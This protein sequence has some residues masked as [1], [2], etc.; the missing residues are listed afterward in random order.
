[1]HYVIIGNSAA[2]IGA[3]EAIRQVDPESPLTIISAEPEG[4]YSRAL[5]SYELAGWIPEGHLELRPPEFYREKNIET[6]LGRRVVKIDPQAKE[7]HLDDG[8][9][10][11][12]DKLLLATGGSPQKTGVKGEDKQGI[13]GFRTWGDLKAISEETKSVK[14]GVV[15]GGGCIGLQAACGLHHHGVKTTLAIA[16][17]HLLSQ[18]ADPECGDFFRELFEKNGIAVR[19]NAR[20]MEFKG[21][22]RVVSILFEDGSELPAQIV[23]VGKG[24]KPNTDLAEGTKIRADWG[25]ITDD[26]MR[27]DEADIFAA[28]DVA[29]TRD[30]ITDQMTVNAVW[31]CAYQQGRVAGLNMAGKPTRYEG[32]LRMNAADFFGVSF[33]SLG[34]VKPTEEGYETHV[35]FQ[36]EK[37]EYRKLIFREE[38]LVGAVLIGRVGNAGVLLNLMRKKAD[39]SDIK[40]DLLEGN[41]EFARVAPLVTSRPEIFKEQEYHDTLLR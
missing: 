38:R 12:Y 1:M 34:V 9:R 22:D 39:V 19:T 3:A 6:L 31:P 30:R 20:P 21:A 23:V 17:P 28:G 29:L 32:S 33:I 8:Q 24:V 5:I 2:G 41:F 37:G 4:A 25:I 14:E 11:S 18:V 7:V 36:R 10:V 15:L 26:T 40:G 16:S 27:T 13:F 35:H